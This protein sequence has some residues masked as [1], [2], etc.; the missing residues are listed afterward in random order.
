MTNYILKILRFWRICVLELRAQYESSRVGVLWIPISSLLFSG[1]LALV[2]R[3]D[4]QFAGRFGFF[5]Y[6]L[7]GYTLWSFIARSFTDSTM[8]IQKRYT[9]SVHNGMNMREMYVKALIER[10]L[11][12]LI[13]FIILF[14]IVIFFSPNGLSLNLFLLLPGLVF[15]SISSL[16]ISYIVNVIS[17]LVADLAHIIKT[18][19]RLLFFA[20]P[21]F[22][23]A[24]VA[25]QN[26]VRHVLSLYNPVGYYLSIPRQSLSITPYHSEDWIVALISSA[27]LSAIALIIYRRTFSFIRNI[28]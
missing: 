7:S 14:F 6:V 27:I 13:N 16:A 11:D 28:R 23:Y 17:V 25:E 8:L 18:G 26:D 1:V 22:W 5:C 19:V 4:S 20:S 21:V 10:L 2:F 3:Y 9:A 12:Y 15:I 24:G